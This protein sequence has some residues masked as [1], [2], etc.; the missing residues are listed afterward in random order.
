[1]YDEANETHRWGYDKRSANEMSTHNN[2]RG[3]RNQDIPPYSPKVFLES[4]VRFI[5]AD[6]QVSL[7]DIMFVELLSHLSL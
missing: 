5:V 4:L 3:V 1:V 7:N 6:D 2:G